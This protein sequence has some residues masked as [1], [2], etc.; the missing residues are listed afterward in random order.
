MI[1]MIQELFGQTLILTR[2]RRHSGSL[3][4]AAFLSAR[5]D[6]VANI[7]IIAAG[8]VTAF[9][10]ASAWPDLIVGLGIAGMN[11]DAAREVWQA[12]REEHKSEVP[13]PFRFTAFDAPRWNRLEH[14][15]KTD[16]R[17]L[18]FEVSEIKRPTKSGFP[19]DH[20]VVVKNEITDEASMTKL[21]CD[22]ALAGDFGSPA[23]T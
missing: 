14:E 1:H 8:L 22:A 9:L 16:L 21:A 15:V 23:T 11:A 13:W 7:F 19:R 4:R 18:A 3:T 10:W 20:S 5:N 17:L 2:Y 6:A 12:A